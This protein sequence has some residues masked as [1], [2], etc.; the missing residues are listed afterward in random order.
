MP[1]PPERF[2]PARADW[3]Q[4][5]SVAV[6]LFALYALTSPRSVALEDDGL[7]VLSS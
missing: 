4:A 2:R 7:F 3:I 5:C 6:V 1:P